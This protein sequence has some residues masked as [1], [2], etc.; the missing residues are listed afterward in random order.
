VVDER[1][2]MSELQRK[3]QP[4][5]CSARASCR[6]RVGS[7][8][9]C[10]LECTRC[11]YHRAHERR[12]RTI[13][14]KV[15]LLRTSHPAP[16]AGRH[17]YPRGRWRFRLERSRKEETQG[18]GEERPLSVAITIAVAKPQAALQVSVSVPVS[19]PVPV[20]VPV[21][22]LEKV[23]HLF[24]SH[25]LLLKALLSL[26]DTNTGR[27]STSAD[28]DRARDHHPHGQAHPHRRLSPPANGK[29]GI[30]SALQHCW[31]LLS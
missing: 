28:I 16:P 14:S 10:V 19:V 3:Q 12:F 9:P 23:S 21:T 20:T 30:A 1:V 5:T 27:R 24:L 8:V 22:L 29:G 17:G 2:S 18:E 31:L 25:T 13:S 4:L 6:A 15:F 7:E 11:A 26:A